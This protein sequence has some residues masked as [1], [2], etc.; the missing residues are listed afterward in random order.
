MSDW[1]A[2]SELLPADGVAVLVAVAPLIHVAEL[3]T[4]YWW[5]LDRDGPLLVGVTHWMP[6]PPLPEDPAQVSPGG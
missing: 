1:I 4:G 6:L 3:D 2:C 5:M